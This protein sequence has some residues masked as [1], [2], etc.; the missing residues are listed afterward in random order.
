MIFLSSF[1][2]TPTCKA[3]GHND[4]GQ[5]STWKVLSTTGLPYAFNDGY[6]KEEKNNG[7]RTQFLLA[8][9][10]THSELGVFWL[11]EEEKLEIFSI[12]MQI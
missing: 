10:K 2:G 9:E 4:V 7:K 12:S 3:F 8:G 11:N 1:Y 6:M 5:V